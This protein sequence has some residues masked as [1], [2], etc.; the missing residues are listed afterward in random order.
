[1]AKIIK[2]LIADDLEF[3]SIKNYCDKQYKTNI[4]KYL[5]NNNIYMLYRIGVGPI[6]SAISATEHYMTDPTGNYALVGTCGSENIEP[7]TVIQPSK[8]YFG[9]LQSDKPCYSGDFDTPNDLY[10]TMNPVFGAIVTSDQFV[11]PDTNLN[12]CSEDSEI[13][14]DMESASVAMALRGKVRI[15]KCVTDFGDIKDFRK[16]VEKA[17]ILAF[18]AMIESV[19][20][21]TK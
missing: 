10:E 7:F 19:T 17:S 9:T 16:N 6:K 12:L 18:K 4:G 20:N 3:E 2:V 21:E 5:I 8:V 14:Y 13:A 15:F 1:M 11:T